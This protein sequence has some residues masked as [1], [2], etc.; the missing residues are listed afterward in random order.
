LNKCKAFT[1][2]GERCKRQVFQDTGYCKTH[3]REKFYFEKSVESLIKFD[4]GK[5]NILKK[6]I[7]YIPLS[8]MIFIIVYIL[9]RNND[10]LGNF[11]SIPTNSTKE[12]FLATSQILATV[13]GFYIAILILSVQL[14]GTE[15]SKAIDVL[16]EKVEE[17]SDL[18]LKLPENLAPLK[19]EYDDLLFDLHD[20]I[21]FM[22]GSEKMA[23]SDK[24]NAHFRKINKY[25]ETHDV[26]VEYITHINT[27]LWNVDRIINKS[28]IPYIGSIAI[29]KSSKIL[30]KLLILLGI[31]L[32]LYLIFGIVDLQNIFPNLN[33]PILFTYIYYL[34]LLLVEFGQIVFYL[35]ENLREWK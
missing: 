3:I 10:L 26:Q 22:L 29:K 27:Y 7:F 25:I 15:R 17:I 32:L 13:L 30:T 18:I 2:K 6:P 12:F 4:N 5:K 28:V 1:R 20:Q 14:F 35:F 23:S 11:L 33:A 19:Q 24:L 8:F 9:F 31:S 16:Q 21:M 34:V